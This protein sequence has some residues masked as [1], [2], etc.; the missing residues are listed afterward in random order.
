MTLKSLIVLLLHPAISVFFCCKNQSSEI[1]W[2]WNWS[3]SNSFLQPLSLYIAS[4]VP[5]LATRFS[6]PPIWVD[7]NR[8]N[9]P[10]EKSIPPQPPTP[11]PKK[12]KSPQQ[13]KQ[14]KFIRTQHSSFPTPVA[15]D[16]SSTQMCKA[17]GFVAKVPQPHLAERIGAAMTAMVAGVCEPYKWHHVD[18]VW[19]II[20]WNTR[21]K[22]SIC[23]RYN[24]VT[25]RRNF[26]EMANDKH[27]DMAW[28]SQKFGH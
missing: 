26:Q 1:G 15:W 27:Y 5:P 22:G 9:H 17:G 24:P 20:P 11:P 6:T 10:S 8:S 4:A 28:H 18:G 7:F 2:L 3:S 19:L 13:K 23:I 16:T 21:Y 12:P 25:S 14:R